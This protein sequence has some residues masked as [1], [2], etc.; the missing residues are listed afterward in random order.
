MAVPTASEA[1][2]APA[3]APQPAPAAAPSI[4]A[5]TAPAAAPGGSPLRAALPPAGERLSVNTLAAMVVGALMMAVG[6]G[7]GRNQGVAGL[8]GPRRGIE[9]MAG[10]MPAIRAPTLCAEAGRQISERQ[11]GQSC[12]TP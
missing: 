4:P 8:R 9:R 2:P 11:R 10:N 7:M 3:P 6:V 5:Q 12:A 1:A